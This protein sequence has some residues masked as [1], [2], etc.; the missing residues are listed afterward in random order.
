MASLTQKTRDVYTVGILCAMDLERNAVRYMLDEE[1]RRL[2][3]QPGDSNSYTLGELHGHNVVLACL[4][5]QQG[6]GAAATVATNMSRSFP[7]IKWRLFVGIGGG[8]PSD[9]HDIRLGD[10]VISMPEGEHAGVVQYDLKRETNSGFEL[11]G[12]LW[13]LPALLRNAAQDMRSDHRGRDNMI[14]EY[15]EAMV[16]KWPRM[17]SYKQPIAPDVLFHADYPHPPSVPICNGNCDPSRAVTRPTRQFKGPEIHYGLIASGDSVIKN[18]TTRDELSRRFAGDVLCFEMEAAGL[19]TEYPSIV[20]RGISDYADSHKNNTWQHY[21]AATA[22]ACAKELLSYINP[23][24]AATEPAP[25][26]GHEPLAS[27]VFTG[28]GIQSTGSVHIGR[29]FKIIR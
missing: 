7:S 28:Q 3:S 23:E 5:S 14:E 4:P 6:K 15:I 29:D 16:K 12:F 22:A 24:V 10:V 25:T 26:L 18:A 2:P 17:L 19:M 9:K 21:A 1:H 20:I 13:P 27:N 11:K 8:V